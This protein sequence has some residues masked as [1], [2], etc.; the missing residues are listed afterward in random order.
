[1]TFRICSYNIQKFSSEKKRTENIANLIK[2]NQIDVIAIQ[3]IFR[4]QPLNSILNHLDTTRVTW[5]G[6]FMESGKDGEGYA[7]I[8]NAN[9]LTLVTGK[10]LDGK[11]IN[12]PQIIKNISGFVRPPFYIRFLPANTRTP[13]ELRLLTTHIR[14]S[15]NNK[16]D[17]TENDWDNPQDSGAIALRRA[18][19]DQLIKV[20]ENLRLTHKE[21]CGAK[22]AYTILL[23]DYNLCLA[24]SPKLDERGKPLRSV[25]EKNDK[26]NSPMRIETVQNHRTT[27]RTVPEDVKAMI[28]SGQPVPIE[29]EEMYGGE[30]L[31]HDYDHFTFDTN[32]L[33][34]PVY[35]VDNVLGIKTNPDVLNVMGSLTP[36]WEDVYNYRKNYSDHLPIV[37]DFDLKTKK[38]TK[39]LIRK[40]I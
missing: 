22:Y 9:K 16:A 24:E 13:F 33:G 12:N 1:M 34:K 5:K 31:A 3:E 8:W 20:Y 2:N 14:F 25:I 32:Q 26:C 19:F 6:S 37:M 10:S 35:T 7:F 40:E 18:E 27:L 38:A 30:K 15:K 17:E 29:Y 36:K 39:V 23:G 11:E 4:E 21:N 28:E